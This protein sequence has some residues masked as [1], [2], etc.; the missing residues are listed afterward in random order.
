MTSI[1]GQV[2]YK[3][4]KQYQTKFVK[5]EIQKKIMQISSLSEIISRGPQHIVVGV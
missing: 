1:T 3:K 5:C 4:N 2:P